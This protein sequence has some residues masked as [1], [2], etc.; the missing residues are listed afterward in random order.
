M[1]HWQIAMFLLLST[2]PGSVNDTSKFRLTLRPNIRTTPKFPSNS[3]LLTSYERRNTD[4]VQRVCRSTGQVR[5]ITSFQTR[6]A[7]D[8]VRRS[9]VT[10][11]RNQ[12]R[13]LHGK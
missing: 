8:G 5:R 13:E 7:D 4:N 11:L 1:L 9:S 10:A 2:L 12:T 6:W 3:P